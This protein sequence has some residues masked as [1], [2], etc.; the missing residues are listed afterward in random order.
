MKKKID[1][2]F[3]FS[4]PPHVNLFLP[5]LKHIERRGL[6]CHSTAREFVETTG[7]LDKNG[8]EYSIYGRHGGKNRILKALSL[9]KRNY[10]LYT[11][12]PDFRFSI[13]SSFEAPEISWLKKRPAIVFDDN[14]I[15]PNWLYAKF[16]RFVIAPSVIDI[17]AW[18]KN[19][20]NRKKVLQ[21]KGFK[22]DIY[23]AD[24]EPDKYFMEH[25]PFSK[26]VTIRPE[27]LFAAYV[28]K[29]S[30]TIVPELINTLT[31]EGYNILYLPR[32]EKDRE[33]VN[34]QPNIFIP[35]KPL[36]GLDV[37]YYS[38]AVLTGAGTFSREAAILGT[39]AVSFFT[40]NQFLAVDKKMFEEG[41]IFHSRNVKK[42]VNYL[43]NNP[44][45]E[46]VMDITRSKA[47]QNE[48]FT[49]LDKIIIQSAYPVGSKQ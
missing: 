15:A 46:R 21:Y 11:N 36:S 8:V 23:I 38:D 44:K 24:Y 4:N 41:M 37:C 19:G 33:Y 2:W 7:L 39:P 5:I 47:V 48:V 20:I 49:I 45:R 16:A 10:L 30:K 6:S 17:K 29:N 25:L 13:S 34:E 22:E 27:N 42:I 26:F 40:G 14:E 1:I 18:E 3:D 43:K 9:I 12:L 35:D 32:Y 28:P 31:L